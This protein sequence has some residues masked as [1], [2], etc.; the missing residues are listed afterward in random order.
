[1]G[2]DCLKLFGQM[3]ST[4]FRRTYEQSWASVRLNFFWTLRLYTRVWFCSVFSQEFK[5]YFLGTHP[6]DTLDRENI[7][8]KIMTAKFLFSSLPNKSVPKFELFCA[9]EVA[10]YLIFKMSS[11]I[12]A[13]K[14]QEG[15]PSSHVE[16]TLDVLPCA[17]K[18]TLI[19]SPDPCYVHLHI[20]KK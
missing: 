1:M 18:W 20:R 17:M 15:W 9:I 7:Q 8:K 10:E 2:K 11:D 19:S 14:G 5:N 3:L 16:W 4:F 12:L 13:W 6:F